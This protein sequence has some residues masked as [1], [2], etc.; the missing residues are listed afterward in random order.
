MRDHPEY[1]GQFIWSGVDYLGEAGKYPAI[2]NNSGLLYK[3]A[4][5]KPIGFQRQSWWSDTPIVYITRRV[6]RTPLAP[7][8]PGYN[9]IDERRPPVLF[10]DWTPK[11]LQPHEE[12]VEVYSNCEEVELFLNGKSLGKQARPKDDSPRTWEVNFES[13]ILRAVGVNSGKVAAT[14]ELRTAGKPAKIVVTV[15]K[16]TIAD[17]WDDVVFV[18]VSVIDQNGT[19]VPGADNLITFT[20][21]GAGFVAAVDSADNNSHEPY[22]AS[23][24]RAY[25]GKCLA[26]I[27]ANSARGMIK[28]TATS[29]NLRSASIELNVTRASRP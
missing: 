11:D 25:Q 29:P 6:A 28:L 16:K 15:D 18:N 13:G 2:A 20:T 3:T 9:P 22:Q 17:R 24:R 14:Y 8:D 1:S 7:T 19:L 12:N 4:M 21:E 5:P 27:K 10:S 26:L 23:Q